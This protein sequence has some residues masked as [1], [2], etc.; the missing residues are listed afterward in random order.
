MFCPRKTLG[1]H[2]PGNPRPGCAYFSQDPILFPSPGEP[3]GVGV[4]LRVRYN[5]EA[6]ERLAAGLERPLSDDQAV[7]VVVHVREADAIAA[8][9]TDRGGSDSR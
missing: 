1:R 8:L 2:S 6:A 7:R 5:V 3:L 4:R 9:C